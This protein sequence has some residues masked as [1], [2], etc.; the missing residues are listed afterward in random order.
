M[1]YEEIVHER[2]P[3]LYVGLV[4]AY[5]AALM[6][7]FLSMDLLQFWLIACLEMAPPLLILRSLEHR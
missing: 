1:L 5:Q 4:L 2:P 3:G 7:L 6:G